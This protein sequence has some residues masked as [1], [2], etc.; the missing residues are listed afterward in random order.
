[1]LFVI[2]FSLGRVGLDWICNGRCIYL[3]VNGRCLRLY[4]HGHLCIIVEICS[5]LDGWVFVY[6]YVWGSGVCVYAVKKS[7]LG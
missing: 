1:M 4:R 7:S 3:I 2:Y 6:L 5:G